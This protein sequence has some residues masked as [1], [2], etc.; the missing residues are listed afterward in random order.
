MASLGR[1]FNAGEVATPSRDLLPNDHYLVQ[2]V[3]SSMREVRD[4]PAHRFLSVEME[5][6]VGEYQRR[7][8]WENLNLINSNAQTVQIAEQTFAEI[9]KACRKLDIEDSEELHYIPFIIEV[10]VRPDNRT[11]ALPTGHP[12]KLPPVNRIKS[13]KPA[14]GD[15]VPKGGALPGSEAPAQSQFAGAVAP[16]GGGMTTGRPAS[17]TPPWKR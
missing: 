10:E 6:M 15:D 14:E 8:L 2:I 11:K 17:G 4:N 13:Y 1:K 12:D 7:K 9:C 16:S 3:A 5:V